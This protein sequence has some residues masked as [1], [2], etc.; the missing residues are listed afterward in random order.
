MELLTVQ[1]PSLL[2]YFTLLGPDILIEPGA[3]I[4]LVYAPPLM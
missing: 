1:L 3:Q 4:P 2:S